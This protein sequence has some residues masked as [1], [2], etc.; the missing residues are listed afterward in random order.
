MKKYIELL[1]NQIDK[2]K[3]KEFDLEAWKNYTIILLGRIFG[4]GNQKIKQI[5]KIEYD[6]GS[7]S[8]RDT[9][10]STEYME[11]C[12]KLGKVILE[13]SINEIE[14]FGVPE[15]DQAGSSEKV[16]EIILTAIEDELTGSQM[17]EVKKLVT[18][19][20]SGKVKKDKLII[21][22]KSLNNENLARIIANIIADPIF[23]KT[24]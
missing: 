24:L 14:N 10:G 9:S 20:D 1:K 7:W 12:K 16:I 22:L 23:Y 18:S 11:S 3:E 13:A 15:K 17:R 4:E 6:F 19:T 21:K 8:L 2:L 5:E